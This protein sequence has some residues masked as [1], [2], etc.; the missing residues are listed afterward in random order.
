MAASLDTNCL[1]RWVLEDIPKQGRTVESLLKSSPYITVDTLAIIEMVLCWKNLTAFRGNCVLVTSPRL[2][3]TALSAATAT[4]SSQLWQHI[5]IIQL[6]RFWI[7]AWPTTQ[8]ST[9]EHRSSHSTKSWL[10]N[11]SR[12]SCSA[13]LRDVEQLLDRGQEEVDG[14]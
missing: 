14:K 8:N 9:A 7:A 4:Y 6:C 10:I 5:S 3:R 12:H 13:N 1:L 2:R 11:L